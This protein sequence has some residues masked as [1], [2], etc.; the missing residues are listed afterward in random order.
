MEGTDSGV[1]IV[2]QRVLEVERAGEEWR[3]GEL[4]G[5]VELS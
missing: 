2:L 3:W 5:R 1:S 4:S